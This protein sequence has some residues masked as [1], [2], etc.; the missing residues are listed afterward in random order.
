[1]KNASIPHTSKKNQVFSPLGQSRAHGGKSRYLP[2]TYYTGYIACSTLSSL[3]YYFYTSVKFKVSE[4]LC[5]GPEF[6]WDYDIGY[7]IISS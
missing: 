6:S 4:E 1:M 3:P 2:K 7:I 5:Q